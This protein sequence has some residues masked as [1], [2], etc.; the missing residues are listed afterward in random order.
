MGLSSFLAEM[1]ARCLNLNTCGLPA[2]YVGE[3]MVFHE[4]TAHCGTPWL[5]F[6]TCNPVVH[7]AC[8]DSLVVL[9]IFSIFVTKIQKMCTQGLRFTENQ[10][11]FLCSQGQTFIVKWVDCCFMLSA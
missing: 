10:F 5:M 7:R 11:L 9:Y 3:Q 6:L 8:P 1:S 4:N 2:S